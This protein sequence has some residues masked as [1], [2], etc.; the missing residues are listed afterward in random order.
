MTTTPPDIN[1]CRQADGTT[2]LTVRGEIDMSNTALLADAIGRAPG[3][4]LLDFSAVE[5]LDSAGLAVLFACADRIELIANRLIDPVLRVSGLTDL[6]T[7]HEPPPD[8]G[9]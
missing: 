2:A 5:Y 6:I 8:A 1:S 3:P 9:S 4:L 7:V